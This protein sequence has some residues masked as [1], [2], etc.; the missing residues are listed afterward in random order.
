[1]RKKVQQLVDQGV[2][3]FVVVLLNSYVNPASARS[4]PSSTRSATSGTCRSTCR[5]RSRPNRASTGAP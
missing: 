4:S 3:G 1:V 5:T 2:R